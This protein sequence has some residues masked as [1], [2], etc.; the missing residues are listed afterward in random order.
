MLHCVHQPALTLC[1]AEGSR[2]D[3]DDNPNSCI[4][5]NDS[6]NRFKFL[7]CSEEGLRVRSTL[8]C[9][10]ERMNVLLN[11]HVLFIC[12]DFSFLNVTNVSSDEV[13]LICLCCVSQPNIF[14]LSRLTAVEMYFCPNVAI[15]RHRYSKTPRAALKDPSVFLHF[16]SLCN[17]MWVS[18]LIKYLQSHLFL[19]LFTCS[20]FPAFI[21][22]VFL[23]TLTINLRNSA[24]LS[25]E[26]HIPPPTSSIICPHG[27][28]VYNYNQHIWAM[29]WPKKLSCSLKIRLV[30]LN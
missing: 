22:D 25:S 4:T 2:A 5:S 29:N 15:R 26:M 24:T 13:L 3:L 28:F 12:I 7:L 19:G 9:V 1:E 8:P 27:L 17:E 30:Y 14:T 16:G 21:W 11:L 23:L 18:F 10:V 6:L 20:V